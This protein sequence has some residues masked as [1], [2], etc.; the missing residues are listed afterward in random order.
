MIL[1]LLAK[2]FKTEANQTTPGKEILAGAVTFFTMAYIIFL[3]PAILSGS[4]FGT[5]TGMSASSVA[6]ATILAS[7][8]GS[9]TMGL[10]ARLPIALA[11]GMGENFFFALTVIPAAAALNPDKGWQTALGAVM[12]SGILFF[13][14]SVSGA[15]KWIVQAVSPGMKGAIAA[16]IG[17][18]IALI[19]LKNGSI[20]IHSESTGM[21]L[22]P[23]IYGPDA[24]IFLVGLFLTVALHGRKIPGSILIGIVFT[25]LLSLA[26]KLI[27]T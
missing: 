13:I 4:L 21:A 10:Y 27:F 14:L 6:Q 17:L 19:G 9:I 24:L 26:L 2:F 1:S 23:E 25:T 12:I 11:P 20:V 8:L 5:P 22:N 18:F 7:F 3:N 16:G 15:R